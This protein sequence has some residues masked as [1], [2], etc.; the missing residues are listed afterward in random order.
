[1]VKLSNLSSWSQAL[2]LCLV[3]IGC[4][5]DSLREPAM[6]SAA[7]VGAT[8]AKAELLEQS[9]G[10]VY[11]LSI[12]GANIMPDFTP[13]QITSVCALAFFNELSEQQRSSN[14]FVRVN[15][16]P[17]KFA[18]MQATFTSE[19]LTIADRCIENAATFLSWH[20]SMGLDSIRPAID[21]SFFPD[22]SLAF[23]GQSILAQDS[24]DNAWIRTEIMGFR[25][26]TLAKIPVLVLN[27]KS[28]RKQQT[29]WYDVFARYSN[30]QLIFV[31]AKLGKTK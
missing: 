23:I 27:A 5:G 28:I 14:C 4:S 3:F 25:Q 10:N 31:S 13:E 24:A 16:S 22:S 20:P 11:S 12:E 29:Q 9:T 15:I 21:A 18:P 17:D 2:I 30:Q 8:K 19:E 7:L 1:M 26:D 6:K